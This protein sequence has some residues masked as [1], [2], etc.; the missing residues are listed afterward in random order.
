MVTRA[1]N[2]IFCPHLQYVVPVV[3]AATQDT[4]DMDEEEEM[5]EL[6]SAEEPGSAQE[7]LAIP[8][9]KKATEEEISCILDNKK[10]TLATLPAGHRGIRLKWV[11]KLKKDPEGNMVKHKARLVV[12]GYAQ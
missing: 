9:W 5:I 6:V 12:K 8:A 2:G 1:Q 11:F 4:P 10:W 3:N 7:A